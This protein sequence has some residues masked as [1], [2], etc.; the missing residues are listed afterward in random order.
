[1]LLDLGLALEYRD[2]NRDLHFFSVDWKHVRAVDFCDSWQGKLIYFFM[3]IPKPIVLNLG[4]INDDI[5][6]QF[7]DNYKRRGRPEPDMR[8]Q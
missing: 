4:F 5:W 6:V 1:M 3:D 8:R 2:E 7:L